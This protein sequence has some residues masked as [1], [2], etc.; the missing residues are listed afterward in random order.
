MPATKPA[1]WKLISGTHMVE[2]KNWLWQIVLWL[3]HE[4]HGM[5]ACTRTH[6]HTLT[7]NNKCRNTSVQMPSMLPAKETSST[8]NRWLSACFPSPG[9]I[10]KSQG[11]VCNI[12]YLYR[13]KPVFSRR[14]KWGFF[15]S[16]FV[17]LIYMPLAARWVGGGADNCVY[18]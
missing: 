5:H 16:F 11:C 12:T 3:P 10:Y 7:T 1:D 13:W 18:N 6:A 2:G 4:Y 17:T 8:I 14:P 9:S 15:M